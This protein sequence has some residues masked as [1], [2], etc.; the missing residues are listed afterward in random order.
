MR[1]RRWMNEQGWDIADV[2]HNTT[3]DNMPNDETLT[4]LENTLIKC[5]RAAIKQQGGSVNAAGKPRHLYR[6]RVEDAANIRP[7]ATASDQAARVRERFL[8]QLDQDLEVAGPA[9]ARAAYIAICL[10]EVE[11][12]KRESPDAWKAAVEELA[13]HEALIGELYKSPRP[14]GDRLRE[15]ATQ[16]GLREPKSK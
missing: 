10:G 5:A 1:G 7:L 16:A 11:R 8:P 13:K 6:I 3:R 9:R 2:Y 12:L 4:G 14:T 15:S